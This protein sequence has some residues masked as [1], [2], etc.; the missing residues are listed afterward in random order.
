M[1]ASSVGPAFAVA[2]RCALLALLV[3][4]PPA[5]APAQSGPEANP[6]AV[7]AATPRAAIPVPEIAKR[8]EEVTQLLA[9]M[10]DQLAP[11]AEILA[12][13]ERI[14][15][16]TETIRVRGQETAQ[17]IE[18]AP[19]LREIDDL[20]AAW[21]RIRTDLAAANTLLTQRAIDLERAIDTLTGLREDWQRTRDEVKAAGGPATLLE[22]IKNTLTAM[23]DERKALEDHRS[24]TL[25]AL[26]AVVGQTA[27]VDK[28][29]SDLTK[30]R[31]HLVRRLFVRDS[32]P[33]WSWRPTLDGWSETPGRLRAAVAPELATARDY[34]VNQS[35]RIPFFVA[36]F[37]ALIWFL[38]RAQSRTQRWIEKDRSLARVAMV[39]H[40]PVSSA[41]LLTLFAILW[42]DPR[43]P[44]FL[45]QAIA[46]LGIVPMLRM[47]PQ[48]IDPPL[49]IALYAQTGL[50][51]ADRLRGLTAG[52]PELDQIVFFLEITGAVLFL[53][54]L[55][56]S[57][58]L[59]H[60]S[61]LAAQP[62]YERWIERLVRGLFVLLAFAL[63]ATVLG[64]M[65][66]ADLVAGTV[67]FSSYMA[68]A[69]FAGFRVLEGV[70]VAAL[71]SRPA[72]ALYMLQDNQA[73]IQQRIMRVVNWIAVA[74]WA[75]LTLRMAGLFEP[76]VDAVTA[77]FNAELGIG[78]LALSLSDL[79]AFAVTVWLS[80]LLS[81]FTRFV[82]KEDVYPRVRLARGLPYALSNLVHYS[83]LMLGFFLGLAAIGLDLTKFTI[84]AGAFGLGIGFGLQ[85][86]INNF[87]SGLILLFERPV[88]VGD[89]VQIG[90][91]FGE[92]KRIGIRSSTLRTWEGAEVILPNAN[93]IADAVTNWTLSDRMRRI[94]V[95][96]G[97][98]YGSDPERVIAL[99]LAVATAHPLVLK[100]P[101]PV[102]LFIAFGDSAL[103]FQLRAWTAR[104][105]D[106]VPLRSALGVA[107]Y[108]ALTE[109]GIAIPFPQRDLHLAPGE[110]VSVRVVPPQG[111]A[112]RHDGSDE[113]KPRMN[114]DEHG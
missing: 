16:L 20:V 79:L 25:A 38:R 106:S 112:E 47:L 12:I 100:D 109:A 42:T 34:V 65:R 26:D 49:R 55:A 30:A 2:A 69:L 72:R 35:S 108:H 24:R 8:G 6:T 43:L 37:G 85:N 45:R 103:D 76:L 113:K 41:L 18:T 66:L 53:A 111:E 57:G 15:K 81:R 17:K 58:R 71:H 98:A 31:K 54:W 23:R 70:V 99:L 3:A 90:T 110:T 73:L 40:K 39:F 82:L 77:A 107:I 105:E 50:F 29:L 33:L 7:P 60:I 67:L 14:P 5:A 21:E 51:A 97:V 89:A 36:L 95:S 101:A 64:F 68:V 80:F 62:Q 104:F 52:V 86:I 32:L 78:A 91:L 44:Q 19:P 9:R 93:L 102:A 10:E 1:P 74:S 83:I 46:L 63:L 114:T 59:E 28:A 56:R 88:Q 48:L 75:A 27:Q 13:A 61:A 87:V 22:R 94:D 92:I 96:V 11:T 84:L 4:M